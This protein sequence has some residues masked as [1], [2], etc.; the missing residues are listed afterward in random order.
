MNLDDK[1][2]L[3]KRIAQ[4]ID[5]GIVIF[6]SAIAGATI[7]IL[8]I[9]ITVDVLGRYLF[10]TPTMV[11]VEFSGY[12]LVGLV[13]LGLVYTGHVDGHIK[14]EILTDRLK[15]YPRKMLKIVVDI[16]TIVFSAWLAWFTLGPVL[17]DFELGST[18]LT[19]TAIPMW[20]PGA[21]IPLGFAILAMK[22]FAQFVIDL[23]SESKEV[24]PNE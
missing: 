7:L 4:G 11:A 1:N 22:L 10:Q 3:P 19:G 9:L 12:L 18:S 23:G 6:C 13:F 17:M 20:V 16:F 8:S 24:F 21:L 2:N 5:K 14:I 15:P